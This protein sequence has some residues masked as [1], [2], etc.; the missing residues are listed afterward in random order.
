MKPL[1]LETIVRKFAIL[2]MR[3]NQTSQVYLNT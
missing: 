3:H 1:L 2:S